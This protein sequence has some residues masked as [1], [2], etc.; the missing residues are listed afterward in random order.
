MRQ[1]ARRVISG[2]VA[3]LMLAG[4]ALSAQTVSTQKPFEPRVSQPGKDV[5]W[6]PTPQPTVD[7]M[8]DL[9][10]LTK[11][12]F[13]V[14]LGSGDGIIV[15]TAAKRGARAMGVEFNPDMVAY[16]E[17][18]A[19]EAGV[20]GR[21]T[22]KQGDFFKTDFSQATVLTM[23]LLPSL[24]E[25]LRPTI[26]NMKPGTRVVTNTFRMGS[27]DDEWLPETEHRVEPCATSW[28]TAI[29]YVVPAKVE[30][31]WKTNTGTLELTQKYT[32]L[33]GRMG[34]NPITDGK[35]L[36]YGISFTAGGTKY[37]GTV[38]ADGKS[39]TGAN[40]NATR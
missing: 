23:F 31:S 18:R 2:G 24:N 34:N 35:V 4:V 38:S 9:A 7:A 30:G 37:S 8:L 1:L 10:K 15:I 19:K 33:S 16:A 17:G 40:L 29:L 11:D 3:A 14:D 22:F 20:T 39:I 6:V 28:C 25:A 32:T 5:V 36:G 21:A 13:L 26:L 12:D 27:G